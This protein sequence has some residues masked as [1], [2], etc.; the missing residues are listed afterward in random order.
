MKNKRVFQFALAGLVV[1]LALQMAGYRMDHAVPR[2]P[3]DNQVIYNW[4]TLFFSPVAF[5]LRIGSPEGPIVGGWRTFFAVLASNAFLYAAL[6]CIAQAFFVRLQIK[7]AHEN[8]PA[9]VQLHPERVI[10][11]TSPNWK[12]RRA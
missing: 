10:R 12:S 2:I 3:L 5:F 8:I 1:A 6:Y 11:V 9:L 7:L 4:L